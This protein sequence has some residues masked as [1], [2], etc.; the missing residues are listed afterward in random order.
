MLSLGKSQR[1]Y[2]TGHYDSVL[3]E[4]H[5]ATISLYHA[6]AGYDYPIVACARTF[7]ALSG[8]LPK[9]YQTLYEG[10]LAFLVV[11]SSKVSASK[12]SF[13]KSENSNKCLESSVFTR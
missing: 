8:L 11:V 4:I 1:P 13:A 12:R 5:R 10:A 2:I 9:I 7:S 3:H 6:K